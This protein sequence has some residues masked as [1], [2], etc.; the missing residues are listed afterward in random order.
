MIRCF[1]L[2]FVFLCS[3]SSVAQ[4]DKYTTKLQEFFSAEDYYEVIDYKSKKESEMGS[5]S[6]YLKG[7]AWFMVENERQALYYIDAAIEKGEPIEEMY[8]YK[9]TCHLF[10]GEFSEGLSALS[11]AVEMDPK[12]RD[13]MD[14]MA[15]GYYLNEKFDSALIWFEKVA[16]VDQNN[17][18]VLLLMGDC[19]IKL[20]HYSQAIETYLR[21]YESAS[22]NNERREA[23]TW[24]AEAEFRAG[25]FVGCET[26]LQKHLKE[27]PS[28]FNAMALL[29]QAHHAQNETDQVDSLESKLNQAREK[30]STFPKEMKSFFCVDR[31]TS[32][33][34]EVKV[35]KSYNDQKPIPYRWMHQF[36]VYNE[37]DEKLMTIETQLDS[38][39]E[40][41]THFTIC[42]PQGDSLFKYENV[43]YDADFDYFKL[44]E[45]VTKII[46]G[47]LKHVSLV[48]DYENWLTSRKKSFGDGD[49]YSFETAIVV[50][51]ISEEYEY[52]REQYPG[53]RMMMQSLMFEDGVPY[54]ILHI[55]TAEGEEIDIYFNISNFFGKY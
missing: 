43:V 32:S 50:D 36:V 15:R 21:A 53:C 28:D 20:K 27:F 29:I 31:F 9:G 41:Q 46:S 54:D 1:L 51:S 18:G 24:K 35:Y 39:H 48:T 13:N 55:K 16:A 37:N 25:E 42:K 22:Y 52:I 30:K 10:I 7:L 5:M 8:Y 3:F 19:H 14:M 38:T 26:T 17:H 2:T 6:L 44:R 40:G 45:T 23:Q 33:L 11:K 34:G 49:G 12:D 47:E 4:V